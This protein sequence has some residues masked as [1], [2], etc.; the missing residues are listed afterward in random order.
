MRGKNVE[1]LR[2]LARTAFPAKMRLPELKR[3]L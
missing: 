1:E 2:F 3:L